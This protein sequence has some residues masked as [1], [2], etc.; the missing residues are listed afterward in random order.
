M[1]ELTDAAPGGVLEPLPSDWDVPWGGAEDYRI[2]Y[3]GFGR[4]R[5]R[6]ITTPPGTRWHVDVIDT[7][8]MTVDRQPGTFE[9]CFRIGLPGREFMAVRL[10][11]A[12]G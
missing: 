4:P 2:G 9:G 6:D 8:N 1:L 10:I 7:W 12:A 11:R 5:Y 3:F